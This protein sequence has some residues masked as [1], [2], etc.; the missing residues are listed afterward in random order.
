MATDSQFA[1]MDQRFHQATR[2][3]VQ[4]T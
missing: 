2:S 4:A 1:S 3:L